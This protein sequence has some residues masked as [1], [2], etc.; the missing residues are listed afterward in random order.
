[1]LENTQEI[2]DEFF[3]LS[4]E[5]VITEEMF[6]RSYIFPQSKVEEYVMSII[7]TP[8]QHFVDYVYSHYCA[9]PI[10]TS[11]IPQISSYD[12]STRGIC[13]VMKDLNDP[14]LTYIELGVALFEDG[15]VRNNGA[16]L[17]FGENQVKGAAFHG[18]THES[19]KKWFLTCLGYIYPELDDEL[20]QYLSARTLL[21]N[22]FFHIIVAEAVEH[23]VNIIKYMRGLSPSTQSRRSSSCMHFFNVI[24]KQCQLENVPLHAIFFDKN[25][26]N[27]VLPLEDRNLDNQ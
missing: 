24:L 9:K 20:R 7:T 6:E 17:K 16:Y 2:L 10:T 26:N 18:L 11:G 27:C 8:Y 23:D 5:S 13:R 4:F 12:P 21:R 3:A 25:E 22:P 19:Y 15:V 14:G 1:M